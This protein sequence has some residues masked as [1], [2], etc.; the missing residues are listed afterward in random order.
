MTDNEWVKLATPRGLSR[1]DLR[2][3][4][5][6]VKSAP[7]SKGPA[8]SLRIRVPEDAS[9]TLRAAMGIVSDLVGQGWDIKLDNAQLYVRFPNHEDDPALEK[10]RVRDQELLKRDEQLSK[11]SVRS[12]IESMERP[13]AFRNRTVS[14]FSLM[15]DGAE[16]ADRLINMREAASDDPG[17]LRQVIDPYVQVVD[18]DTRCSLTGLRLMDI[19]RYFRHTWTNHYSST[20]GRNLMILIRDRA[21]EFH[22]VVGI[23]AL[24]S[25][26]V[27]ISER[28]EWIG[29]HPKAL[30][31]SI[32]KSPSKR[33]A[34]WLLERLEISVGELYLDDLEDDGLYWKGLWAQPTED[35]I[36]R[37]LKEA[38]TRRQSHY[39]DPAQAGL[40]RS[41]LDDS[42]WNGRARSDLFASKR[43]EVLAQLLKARH[44]LLPHL[45]PP[46]AAGL[47]EALQDKEARRA[48]ASIAR[49]AKADTVGTE[50]ADLVVCGAIPPY[51]EVLG[52]KLV[53][54]L[55]V[56]P[57]VLRAY[58]DRYRSYASQ[59]ASSLAGRPI[60]RRANLVFV[61]TT[62]LYGSGSSQYNRLHMPAAFLGGKDGE[63][64]AFELLGRSRAF[65]TSHLS[66]ETVAA[67][68]AVVT[69][70]RGERHVNSIFGEGGN[71]KLRKIR[72]GFEVLGW[73]A[74]YLLRHNRHRIVY[75]VSLA[76]N[77]RSDLLGMAKRPDY[78]VN[79]RIPNDVESIAD[80]WYERWLAKRIFLESAIDGVGANGFSK[81]RDHGARVEL[82]TSQP[83]ASGSGMP[84]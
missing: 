46:S 67:L 15:R 38:R 42:E 70:E 65:G 1:R 7:K 72:D 78:K 54:M 31:T 48:I 3:L 51:N 17:I 80:W 25:S 45:T 81:S 4:H 58:R 22:C 83:R 5:A 10:K 69:R 75:G 62:S 30:L 26:V 19:W 49:R 41:P 16:L 20:P 60:R 84:R 14:I 50:I 63:V 18:A 43:C 77:L 39:E 82:P 52:G 34:E 53:A 59:I 35:A 68:D 36:K 28:D 11:P 24:A 37:L 64:V 33:F 29:W 12:F 76:R 23:A 27:Q 61:G 21:T 13:R 2:S 73:P 79:T 44:S 71:P 32:E 66:A 74:D 9:A 47:R 55:A 57:T 56:S 40:K 6:F 8:E